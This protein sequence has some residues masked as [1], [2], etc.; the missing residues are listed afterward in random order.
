MLPK[1]TFVQGDVIFKSGTHKPVLHWKVKHFKASAP[2]M[3]TL[4]FEH[5]RWHQVYQHNGTMTNWNKNTCSQIT[6]YTDERVLN[7]LVH[8]RHALRGSMGVVFTCYVYK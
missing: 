4:V 6:L 2:A 8:A 1:S 3:R 7:P 5:S